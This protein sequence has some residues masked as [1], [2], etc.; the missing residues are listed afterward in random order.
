MSG[1]VLAE[2]TATGHLGSVSP[3]RLID[4]PPT[5]ARYPCLQLRAGELFFDAF[6][7]VAAGIIGRDPDGVLDGVGVGTAVADDAYAFDAQQR[8]AAVFGIVE[9]FAELVKAVAVQHGTDLPG[10]APS[11]TRT[12]V[13]RR[14][15]CASSPK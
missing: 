2:S 5:S 6:V 7:D 1:A 4:R 10:E 11:Q 13:Q 8:C 14:D 9:A 15:G 12:D 3:G